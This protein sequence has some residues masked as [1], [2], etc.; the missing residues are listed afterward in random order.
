MGAASN[1]SSS[2]SSSLDDDDDHRRRR[3][4]RKEHHSKSGDK[5][6]KSKKKDKKAKKK[7]SSHRRTTDAT[8]PSKK[9]SNKRR[10]RDDGSD[11]ES[12]SSSMSSS[13]RRRRVDNPG[14]TRANST[15]Y[16]LADALCQLLDDHPAMTEDLPAILVRLATGT[17]LNLAQSPVRSHLSNV[18][19]Q[20]QPYGVYQE[21]VDGNDTGVWKFRA[22]LQ[23]QLTTM[24]KKTDELVLVRVVRSL[25]DQVGVTMEGIRLA[26]QVEHQDSVA[27]NNRNKND[28][29]PRKGPAKWATVDDP[30]RE[31][32]DDAEDNNKKEVEHSVLQLIRSFGPALAQELVSLC[33]TILDGEVISLD[34][35]PDPLLKEALQHL[36]QD[37]CGMIPSEMDNDDDDDDDNAGHVVA[38][39]TADDSSPTMGLGLPDVDDAT[40][41]QRVVAERIQVVQQVC[42]RQAERLTK[43]PLPRPAT[44]MDDDDDDDDGPLLPGH[45]R[46]TF[47]E[48]SAP[49]EPVLGAEGGREEWMLVPGKFD[50]LTGLK[51]SGV[52]R[53]RQFS[54]Q[55]SGDRPGTG[56]PMDPRVAAEIRALREEHEASRGPSLM[57]EHRLRKQQEQREKDDAA[58]RKKGQK[59]DWKWDRSTDLDAGRRV[60]KDALNTMLG[61]A[62]STL[63]D[64]FHSGT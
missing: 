58:R 40:V 27:N 18:L 32:D 12:S 19:R 31:E 10:R 6:K 21:L 22:P 11:D 4:D 1:A 30:S 41:A 33:G 9:K 50:L 49:A 17:S 25:L 39:N 60:D 43:G 29:D 59:A 56:A 15:N 20:L 35:L 62:N 3:K 38:D 64:K 48:A 47:G 61:G 36:F 42:G 57:E 14:G 63:R 55:R 8:K 46:R 24:K 45:T 16:A 28:D 13:K 54:G 44:R 53:N 5:K 2:D 7:K 51:S 52:I 34:G 23:P 26:E 37:T